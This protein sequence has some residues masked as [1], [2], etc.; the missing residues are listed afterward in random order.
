MLLKIRAKNLTG[1]FLLFFF[2]TY[3]YSQ[4][5]T[6]RGT[7]YEKKSGEP[8]FGSN[9]KIK[10][11]GIGASTDINGF[12]QINKLPP[13]KITIEVS[14]I[15]FNTIEFTVEI[16]SNKI[17]T[18]NFFMEEK[19][20]ILDEFE[21]SAEASERKTEVKM[22]VIK[23]TPRDMA[24]VVAIGGEPDFAQYLQTTP[25]VV[26][27]G[28]QGGQMYI[29][30]GSP[31]QNK[32]LLDGM[33]I[34][35]P[36][37]SI[38]F[39][40][41]FDTDIIRSADIYTGGFSAV[42]GGRISSIMDI[43][44]IDGNK[45]RHA[46][47]ISI[48]PFGSKFKME[49]PIKK[50]DEDNIG[51]TAS[52]IF[53]GKTSY[54]E[55]TSKLLYNYID[56]NGL[57]F[58]FTDLFGKLSFNTANGSKINFFGFNYNDRV[59][60]K[61]VSD[62]NWDSWG[63]GSNFVIVPSSSTMLILGRFNISDYKISLTEKDPVTGGNLSPRT[64]RINGFNFGFDFK[65]FLRENE[66]KYGIDINGFATEFDFFNSVGRQIEQNQNTTELAGYIDSKIIK[67]LLVI[68]PSFRAQYYASLRNFSPEP[69]LGIKYNVSEKFRLKGATGLFSQNLISAN[70]DRDVVNLFYG[71]LS[72]PDNLQDS[73]TLSNGQRVERTHNLQKATHA[74]LG[75]EL[76]LS[77]NFT[78]NVEGYYKWFNQLSNINRNKLYNDNINTYTIPD[79]LKK[80]F[81]IESGDA[82]GVD[83]VLKYQG[84]KT[85]IWAVYS[86]GKVTR[87]D[88]LREYAPLFD[89]R[90]NI[91]L[92]GTKTFGENDNWEVNIRWNFG[93]GLPF[94]QT[95]GYYHSIDYA[96]GLNTDITTIN[97]TDL[98]IIYAD[99]N[100]G[101][102]SAYHRFDLAIK[103]H[104]EINKSTTL[105]VTASVTNLYNRQNIF[106]V[107][108]VTTEKVYQLPLLPSLG[109]SF[110]F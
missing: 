28:D 72:G 103:K 73:I 91:N 93:S 108:R 11:T 2:S 29:R 68:N 45:K 40:S 106:Y 102:L 83:V 37:H 84:D 78:L 53:S 105:D 61:A 98:E 55:Q 100:Q 63:V 77:R 95:Q 80:D 31:I 36:F 90:H 76:D 46:G 9:V 107:D 34:Y 30:G 109:L 47:K 42:Y 65:Y 85:Y 35:N 60:Y 74:I 49:G 44:T 69:R 97:S 10:G 101:R 99:L 20:E 33:T 66:I 86:L 26:T 50:L 92:V 15:E 56:S 5:G 18:Q 41:V 58:N 104:V 17:K 16:V 6:I 81:I 82:Y 89:R 48:N 64:S 24:H 79:E 52:Y 1:L 54:L 96:Q 59:R 87:W 3:L 71:F 27:T 88:G 39:F 67:G 7:I 110:K 23:A 70:S 94:T 32:V 75:G 4:T 13:G 43:T 14:N 38:G 12:Y 57:P 25:G 22:S 8:S 21:Y 62:L 19:D 51:N